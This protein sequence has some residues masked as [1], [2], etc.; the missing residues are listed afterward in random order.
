MDSLVTDEDKWNAGLIYLHGGG[1]ISSNDS[2]NCKTAYTL[3]DD[4]YLHG[5]SYGMK[6]NGE[7]WSRLA[8]E[9]L[10]ELRKK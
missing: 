6:K 8:L 3:F 5:K 7:T 4:L 9:Q 2:S 10:N 1:I